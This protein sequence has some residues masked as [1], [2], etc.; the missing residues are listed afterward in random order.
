MPPTAVATSVGTAA[1]RTRIVEPIVFVGGLCSVGYEISASRLLAPYFGDSTFIWANLIGLTLTYLALGYWLGGKAADRWPDPRVLFTITAVAAFFAGL[2]PLLSRPI[3]HASLKAFDQVAVGAFYGALVGTILLFAIPITLLGFVTPFAIKISLRDLELAGKTAGRLYALSTVGSILGSF[4]PVLVFI[5]MVGTAKTF[6]IL[7]LTL[8]LLSIAGLI[9]VRF[10]PGVAGAIVLSALLV[11]AT[12]TD[13]AGAIKPPYLGTLIHEEQ[14]QYNYIQVLK[15]GGDTLLALNE[16]HAIHSIYNPNQLITGGPWDYFMVPPLFRPSVPVVSRG[17]MIGL[18]AGTA[19]REMLAAYPDMAIDG[20]EIDPA[21]VA[22]GRKYF[23]MNEPNLKVFVQDGRYFLRTATAKYDIVGVDAYHQPY[24]PFQ[25]TTKEFFEEIAA[26]LTGQGAAVVNVGRTSTDYR[27]VDAI[28]TT[29]SAV[30]DHVYEI[31]VD[32]YDNTMVIGMNGDASI[33]NFNLNAS[34]VSAFP[35]LGQVA[36]VSVQ[37]GDIREAVPNG[38][39]FTDDRAPVERAVDQ[40][41]LGA[42]TGKDEP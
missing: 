31:D 19:A 12:V 24:I 30:F 22:V 18:A 2:I 29:M 6:L 10:R 20:V 42:A 38:L 1:P 37:T 5:P 4:L 21:V 14:S 35:V 40:M 9:K 34:A 13:P 11:A 41:I 27:L 32:R 36:A 15:D 23:D 16:G 26:H 28:A 17:L 33:A 39:V 25:L 7:S 8:A 3:L